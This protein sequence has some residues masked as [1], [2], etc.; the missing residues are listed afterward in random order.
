MRLGRLRGAHPQRTVPNPPRGDS[1]KRG[2]RPSPA[3]SSSFALLMD[4][5]EAAGRERTYCC[6]ALSATRPRPRSSS[7]A[8]RVPRRLLSSSSTTLCGTRP[9][10]PST[11][12]APASHTRS[13]SE[14]LRPGPCL[15]PSLPALAP[16]HIVPRDG[17][18]VLA[19]QLKE[20]N[21]VSTVAACFWEEPL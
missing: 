4:S 15:Q 19:G 18:A 21:H 7:D 5:G 13:L 6:W 14:A 8:A 1:L 16:N 12:P 10:T 9:S 2:C 11:L 3:R 20:F 17:A